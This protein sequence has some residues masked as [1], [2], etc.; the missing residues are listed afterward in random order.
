MAF[1]CMGIYMHSHTFEHA[2]IICMLKNKIKQE[3]EADKPGV[4]KSVLTISSEGT[5]ASL[6]T[7][8]LS[9]LMGSLILLAPSLPKPG[10]QLFLFSTV[11]TVSYHS[12]A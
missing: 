1:M 3:R 12:T 5:C 7:I 8:S 6:A 9:D 10:K 4:L 11:C 2:Y